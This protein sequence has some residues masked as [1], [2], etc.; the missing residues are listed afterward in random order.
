[1]SE[2]ER[3]RERVRVNTAT[4]SWQYT[5][6]QRNAIGRVVKQLVEVV[7]FRDGEQDEE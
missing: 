5:W 7:G 1:V 6:Y 4:Y 2:R 3:E